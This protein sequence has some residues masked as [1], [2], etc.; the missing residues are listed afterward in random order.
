MCMSR[1]RESG[2][3]GRRTV[4]EEGPLGSGE[5]EHGGEDERG[6]VPDGD[7]AHEEERGGSADGGV[8]RPLGE[9]EEGL[10]V[11]PSRD[12]EGD[13]AVPRLRF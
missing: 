7:G 13:H 11:D 1:K 3:G 6:A 10:T 2:A 4:I 9:G 12:G 5:D 8:P